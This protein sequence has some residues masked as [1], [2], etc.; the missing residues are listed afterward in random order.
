[1]R[2]DG[3]SECGHLLA[4][5]GPDNSVSRSLE[6][7]RNSFGEANRRSPSRDAMIPL[8]P[9]VAGQGRLPGRDEAAQIQLT[10]TAE[11]RLPKG[12]G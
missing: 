9:L 3:R 4:S 12:H 5:E 2:E 7:L 6:G 10:L 1:M 11:N 8:M